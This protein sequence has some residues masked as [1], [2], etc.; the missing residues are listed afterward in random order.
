VLAAQ[1]RHCLSASRRASPAE[2]QLL[3]SC[4]QLCAM[5]TKVRPAALPGK[6]P[7]FVGDL[8]PRTVRISHKAGALRIVRTVLC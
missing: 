2:L 5:R 1:S 3:S 4:G 7:V 8:Q 6:R